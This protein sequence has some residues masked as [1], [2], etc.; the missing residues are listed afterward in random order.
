MAI[1][2]PLGRIFHPPGI[3]SLTPQVNVRVPRDGAF[4]LFVASGSGY[5]EIARL[6]LS[7]GWLR[8]P[9]GCG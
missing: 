5:L 3:A 6:I 9:R 7:N 4:A 1:G 2:H 8:T